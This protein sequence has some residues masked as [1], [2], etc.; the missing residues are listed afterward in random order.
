MFRHTTIGTAAITGMEAMGITILGA[1]VNTGTEIMAIIIPIGMEIDIG[2][3]LT[4][5]RRMG[6]THTHI[7]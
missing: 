2:T 3:G 6:I 4:T 5:L 1:E 7:P